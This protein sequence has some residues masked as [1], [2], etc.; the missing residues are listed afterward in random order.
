MTFIVGL[1]VTA[2]LYLLQKNFSMK[3]LFPKRNLTT[4]IQLSPK[5]VAY[6][7]LLYGANNPGYSG[8]LEVICQLTKGR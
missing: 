2:A 6:L 7:R 8:H 4:L 3:A 1:P 5:S